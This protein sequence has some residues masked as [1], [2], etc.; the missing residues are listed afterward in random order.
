MGCAKKRCAGSSI[1]GR[2]RARKQQ[3]SHHGR[4]ELRFARLTPPNSL[5]APL[6][7]H[8]QQLSNACFSIP[9]TP[10]HANAPLVLIQAPHIFS[11]ILLSVT[12]PSISCLAAF[13]FVSRSQHVSL[14]QAVYHRLRSEGQTGSHPGMLDVHKI[15]TSLAQ[16]SYP[17]LREIS[18]KL[19]CLWD[20]GRLQRAP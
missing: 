8:Q 5:D 2:R 11:S 4:G 13:Q 20:Q 6:P 7:L 9:P 16:F 10:P 3:T 18:P 14:E 12:F 17:T 15:D 19:I 1:G